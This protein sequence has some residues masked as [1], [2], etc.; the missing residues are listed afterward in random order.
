MHVRTHFS[1][2]GNGWTDYAETWCVVRVPLAL[3][4][5][6]GGGYPHERACSF[7]TFNQIRSFLP[8]NRPKGVLHVWPKCREKIIFGSVVSWAYHPS[9]SEVTGDAFGH[10]PVYSGLILQ[11]KT[12]IWSDASPLT[13][14]LRGSCV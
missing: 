5:T 1:N 8:V 9:P 14:P 4:C 13:V 10:C 7:S 6:K 3:R 2:L 12:V 11:C